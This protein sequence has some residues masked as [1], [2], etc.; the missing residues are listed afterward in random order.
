M[1]VAS[2]VHVCRRLRDSID[3]AN[4]GVVRDPGL[5]VILKD[6]TYH[7]MSNCKVAAAWTRT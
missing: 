2:P 1:D 5:I 4:F 6:F 7:R 3:S